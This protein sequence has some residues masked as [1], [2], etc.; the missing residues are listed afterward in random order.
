MDGQTKLAS[1]GSGG[2]LI[3]ALPAHISGGDSYH[4]GAT[5]FRFDPAGRLAIV[6]NGITGTKWDLRYFVR[7]GDSWSNELVTTSAGRGTSLAYN[8]VDGTPTI[9]YTASKGSGQVLR[10]AERRGSSWTSQTVAPSTKGDPELVFDPS[11]RPAVLS[12][13]ELADGQNAAGFALRASD[14]TWALETVEVPSLIQDPAMSPSGTW[15]YLSDCTLAFDPV[16]GDFSAAYAAVAGGANTYCDTDSWGDCLVAVRYCE[17]AAGS[18][19]RWACETVD[20]GGFA[21]PGALAF[22]ADGT[23]YLTDRNG[24]TR[25]VAFRPPGGAWQKEYVDWNGAGQ[26]GQACLRIGAQGQVG[27]AYPSGFDAPLGVKR[28]LVSFALRPA[29]TPPSP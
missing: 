12:R 11:G 18:P 15:V 26:L 21:R 10:V 5:D 13:I 2:W 24:N 4:G 17:R 23:A 25:F 19:A 28:G 9:A 7:S 27:V 29:P 6:R 20:S 8:P 22:A 14:G 3:E 1:R 16:R